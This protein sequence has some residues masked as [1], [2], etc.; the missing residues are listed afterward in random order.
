M[1]A[2]VPRFSGRLRANEKPRQSPVT[3]EGARASVVAEALAFK[4]KTEV[5]MSISVQPNAKPAV[6]ATPR[7]PAAIALLGFPAAAGVLLAGVAEWRG[8]SDGDVMST[9]FGALVVTMT[10][11]LSTSDR[12]RLGESRRALLVLGACVTL[13]VGWCVGLAL[14]STG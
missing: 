11:V 9:F 10:W 14:F 12:Y 1:R 13:V 7:V 6:D 8:G 5:P 4:L 3:Q 2:D